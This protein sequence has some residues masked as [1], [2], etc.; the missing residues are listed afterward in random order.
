MINYKK[1]IVLS[2]VFYSLLK[3]LEDGIFSVNLKIQK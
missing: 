1:T 3:Y 2:I